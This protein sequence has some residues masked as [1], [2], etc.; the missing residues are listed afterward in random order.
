[1]SCIYI[2]AIKSTKKLREIKSIFP[3]IGG[4]VFTFFRNMTAPPEFPIFIMVTAETAEIYNTAM[5]LKLFIKLNTKF[6]NADVSICYCHPFV[7]NS[8]IFSALIKLTGTFI[9]F[10]TGLPSIIL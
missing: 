2:S 10:S 1:M 4:N 7:L 6:F 5:K 3:G 8:F 9:F